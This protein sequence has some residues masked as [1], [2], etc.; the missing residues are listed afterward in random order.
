[1]AN[2]GSNSIVIEETDGE[3]RRLELRGPGLPFQGASWKSSLAMT[4]E[5]YNGN[6]E[7]T[8]QILGPREMPSDWEGFW[9][10]TML[11]RCPCKYSVGERSPVSVMDPRVLRD[12]S[13]SMFRGGRR[14]KVSW[15]SSDYNANVQTLVREGRCKEWDF[16]HDRLEDISWKFQFEWMGR[17]V[18]Q[19]KAVDVREDETVS[20]FARVSSAV[21]NFL[22]AQ[23]DAKI[24]QY[25][26]GFKKSASRLTLGQLE[27]L[28]K[29]PT[30]MVDS[31]ARTLQKQMTDI[32]RT[33]SLADKFRRTPY[34]VANSSINAIRNIVIT[35]NQ[36]Y[37]RMSRR[38]PE[39]YTLNQNVAALTRSASYFGHTVEQQMLVSREAKALELV[40]RRQIATMGSRNEA[41]TGATTNNTAT[42]TILGV[43]I[44]RDGDTPFS[45]SMRWYG[46]PDSSTSILKANK[47]PATLIRLPAGR[48]LVIPVLATKVEQQ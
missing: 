1:M 46:N 47:L 12:L 36:F 17:G 16:A 8:Q 40:Q 35:A 13:D 34:N 32:E 11:I 43:H 24:R 21:Q 15:I 30:L 27:N 19:Q 20:T 14:L 18:R 25:K 23:A 29:A 7:A 38:P 33:A 10:L 42:R 26:T 28:A 44:V 45:I 31:F 5:W 48:P 6:V 9:R 41:V 22:R 37:D 2:S 39:S 4:T 3:K